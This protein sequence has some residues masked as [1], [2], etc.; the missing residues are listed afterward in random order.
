MI[1]KISRVQLLLS[2][3]QCQIMYHYTGFFISVYK[4]SKML[5]LTLKQFYNNFEMHK[6]LNNNETV[7]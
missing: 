3:Y 5:L 4:L 6:S 1:F 7:F 2:T